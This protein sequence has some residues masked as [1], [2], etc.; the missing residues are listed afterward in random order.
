[1]ADAIFL[2][3]ASKQ[4]VDGAANASRVR[5]IV[6]SGTAPDEA[7]TAA[8]SPLTPQQHQSIRVF[9][10]SAVT[11]DGVDDALAWLMERLRET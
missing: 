6:V 9:G 4:D 7:S 11:G 5:E 1:M 10:V 2:I 8:A 3:L